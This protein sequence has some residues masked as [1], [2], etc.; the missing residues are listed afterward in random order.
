MPVELKYGLDCNRHV[1]DHQ[2]PN[3][4]CSPGFISQTSSRCTQGDQ[5]VRLQ[6][7]KLEAERNRGQIV[8]SSALSLSGK[9]SRWGGEH[10][11]VRRL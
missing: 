7:S 3:M 11:A 4:L 9:K 6:L 1:W 2:K 10:Q 8:L 5:W